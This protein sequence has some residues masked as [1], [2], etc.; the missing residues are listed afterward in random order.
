VRSQGA[1][2][3]GGDPSSPD[4]VERGQRGGV[5]GKIPGIGN[6]LGLG[7]NNLMIFWAMLF[8]E[9]SFGFYQTLTPIYIESLGASPGIVG[10]VIGIG[11]LTRL[12]FLAPGGWA[13]DKI[14][15]RKLI[16]TGR[17]LTILGILLYGLAPTW[18]ALFPAILVMSA[19]NIVW[20][21]VSKVIADSTDS[22]GRT[23]AFTLI[24]TVGPSIALLLSPSLGGLL[25]DGVSLRSIFF[26]AAIAQL[27]SVLLFSR[28]RPVEHT[29][30]EHTESVGFRTVLRYRPV[31]AV[32]G[33]FLALLLVLTTGYTLVP[34][35]L[36][37]EHGVG[38]G[39][40]G[41]FGSIFALG[42]ILLGVLIAKVKHFSPPLNALILTTS[43]SPIAFLLLLGGGNTWVFGLAFLFRGGYFVSWGLIYAILGEVSP[44]RL[45]SRSFALAEVLGGFGFGIAP[46]IAG[47]LYEIE[48]TLPLLAALLA[49]PPLMLGIL[50]VR[51]YVHGLT[52][53][54]A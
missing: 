10:L 37:D 12:I 45:R 42:S 47:A 28:L 51:R 3:V 22:R 40:I 27:G 15:L 34:N 11:G 39:T 48:P 53:V 25:A 43:M 9:A 29:G 13:A 8:N 32:C 23:R 18:W 38:I 20:P 2:A 17:S 7:H 52:P 50:L 31:V 19:G 35:Y 5:L 26:A 54:A 44:E 41:Q 49:I 4:V 24:Y 21:S 16:V 14:P 33:L 46:F 1:E 6:D 36:E 30:E